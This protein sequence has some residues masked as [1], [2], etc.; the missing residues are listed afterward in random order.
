MHKY[1]ADSNN[2]PIH[3]T[4]RNQDVVCLIQDTGHALLGVLEQGESDNVQ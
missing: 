4:W 2:S 3:G 1:I